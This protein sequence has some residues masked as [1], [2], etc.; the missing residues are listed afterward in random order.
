MP[1]AAILYA[2]VIIFL[3]LSGIMAHDHFTWTLEVSWVIIGLGILAWMKTRGKSIT[4][5]LGTGLFIHALVLIYGGWYTYEKVPLG[6]WLS[7]LFN[8]ERNHYDRIGHFI[9]GFVPAILCREVLVK[10]DVVA[11]RKWREL[12]VFAFIMAF[13]GIFELLE[14]GAAQAFGQG[15]DAFLGSQGDVWDAQRDMLMCG[16]GGILSIVLL[17]KWHERQL[18]NQSSP[19]DTQ[20]EHE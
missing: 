4:W 12:I 14:F 8:F 20:G 6:F 9:Q 10:N 19:T 17:A 16:I 18:R 2:I 7:D 5:I 11:S 15:A 1:L 3:I 13:T